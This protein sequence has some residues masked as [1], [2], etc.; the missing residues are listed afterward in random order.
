MTVFERNIETLR[1]R[2]PELA[3]RVCACRVGPS[4][5]VQPA[6]SGAPTLAVV[7]PGQ[8]PMLLHSGRDPLAEACRLAS[9][10]EEARTENVVVLGL[11]LGYHVL[12]YLKREHDRDFMLV[13]E[14]HLDRFRCCLEH[15]D[16]AGAIERHNTRFAVGLTPL[17]VFKMLRA[18]ECSLV[19]NGLKALKHPASIALDQ[20]YYT[21]LISRLH[22]AMYYAVVN[23]NS[24]DKSWRAYAANMAHNAPAAL[25]LPGVNGLFGTFDGVPAIVVSAGPSLSKN[26]RDLVHVK[27]RAV[28]IAVDTALR[29]LLEHGV[30]PDLVVSIDF[31]SNNLRYFDGMD[32]SSLRLVV[33]SEVYPPI[34]DRFEGRRFYA[35]IA[36]KPASR[37]FSNAIGP[38][39]GLD[40]GLSVAHTAFLL[41]L[42]MGCRPIALIGQDLAYTG[43]VSHAK[44]AAMSRVEEHGPGTGNVIAVPDIFGQPVNSHASMLVFLRHFE[45]LFHA[46]ADRLDGGVIDATEGGARIAGTRLMTLKE[47]ILR[48][49]TQRVDIDRVLDAA[50]TSPPPTD[51]AHAVA[52]V[53]TMR[54][55]LKAVVRDAGA[56][57]ATLNA[58]LQELHRERHEPARL[59]RLQTRYAREAAALESHRPAFE[60]MADGLTRAMTT[61]RDRR[62][63][64]ASSAGRLDRGAQ[65][66]A[67]RQF[68]SVMDDVID[69]AQFWLGLLRE[70]KAKIAS[71][72]AVP[73]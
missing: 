50:A 62:L 63:I 7:V 9:K 31:T 68:V 12:E 47:F 52:E 49:G 42:E 14:P 6:A 8:G 71:Q 19:Q 4:L 29:V 3:E 27:G 60:L 59:A 18:N 48:W 1:R 5:L 38:R 56:C 32:T 10:Y 26:V 13:V 2:Q 11:G 39:G 41:A 37:W 35:E 40:K 17:E 21:E 54:G 20:P 64:G 58:I 65:A 72:A 73:A 28:I 61:M 22:D 33:D 43:D 69:A 45:E 44:G 15:T 67:V 23:N 46:N 53:E 66:G 24:R 57:R 30:Q 34:L 70:V 25:S 51:P 36:N 16:F 55:E